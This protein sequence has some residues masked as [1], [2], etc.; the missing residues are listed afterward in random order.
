MQADVKYKILGGRRFIERKEV[1][2]LLSYFQ[3]LANPRNT[4]ALTRNINTPTR[5]IG[6]TTQLS[7]FRWVERTN[8]EYQ[9]KN[10]LPPTL[11][12]YFYAIRLLTESAYHLETSEIDL[13]DDL[14]ESLHVSLAHSCPLSKREKRVLSKYAVLIIQ[15]HQASRKIPLSG[16]IN[17]TLTLLEYRMYLAQLSDNDTEMISERWASIVEIMKTAE[18]Y[19]AASQIVG[20]GSGDGGS[21]LSKLVE[22]YDCFQSIEGDDTEESKAEVV[23]LMTIHASKGLEFDVVFLSGAEEGVLPL[24]SREIDQE[25]ERR[26]A[27]VAITRAKSLLIIT[28][29]EQLTQ[30]RSNGSQYRI[31]SKPSRFLDSLKSLP[32]STCSWVH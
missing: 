7:F 16:L 3:L 8:A 4:S 25:E 5:G 27:Y 13:S 26:L 18:R 1:K 32:N 23:Q 6:E 19:D 28:Y 10:Y 11:L 24:T 22:Y 31:K 14:D 29:R 21:A 17:L 12:D 20:D 9:E 30:F 2:D 15:L